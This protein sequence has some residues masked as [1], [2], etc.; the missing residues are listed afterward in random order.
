MPRAQPFPAL[1]KLSYA[2]LVARGFN[3]RTVRECSVIDAHARSSN[4]I[5]TS[6]LA[7]P[8]KL[9]QASFLANFTISIVL[10]YPIAALQKQQGE[11]VY[12]RLSLLL[13]HSR[14]FETNSLLIAHSHPPALGQSRRLAVVHPRLGSSCTLQRDASLPTCQPSGGV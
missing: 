7:V 3:C 2:I 5:P 10:H 11:N 14:E 13:H 9:S 6:A 8:R 4:R 12:R 1:S